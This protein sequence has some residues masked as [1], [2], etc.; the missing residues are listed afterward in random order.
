MIYIKHLFDEPQ[1]Y[2]S[3]QWNL[4]RFRV[5]CIVL[6]NM[7]N[8]YYRWWVKVKA[9]VATV[10]LVFSWGRSVLT[11]LRTSGS[12][13]HSGNTMGSRNRYVA[14]LRLVSG[15][16]KDR[17]SFSSS[18]SPSFF[19]SSSSLSPD[20]LLSSPPLSSSPLPSEPPELSEPSAAACRRE[21]SERDDILIFGRKLLLSVRPCVSLFF[22]VTRT[23]MKPLHITC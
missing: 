12:V 5:G 9:L 8:N 20:S 21:T 10:A 3:M 11:R 16:S 7:S 19:P 6:Q 13:S 15:H 14:C 18:S 22:D 1:L 2:F 23:N 4:N 17:G